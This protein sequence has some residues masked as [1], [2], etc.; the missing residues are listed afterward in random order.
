M[1]NK[2]AD[3]W[4][5]LR[6]PDI[7]WRRLTSVGDNCGAVAYRCGGG[8][9]LLSWGRCLLRIF[10]WS[11]C[12][13]GI[14]GLG[15]MSVEDIYDPD[16]SPGVGMPCERLGIRRKTLKGYR[17]IVIYLGLVSSFSE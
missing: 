12:W 4:W 7:G 16:R 17:Y 9:V 6:I 11:T 13:F 5:I 1:A 15:S 14:F 2:E 3:P 8:K 10:G